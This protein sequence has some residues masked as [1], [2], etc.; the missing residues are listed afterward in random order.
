MSDLEIEDPHYFYAFSID[1]S[2]EYN[3]YINNETNTYPIEFLNSLN[4]P[5]MPT[6]MLTL[7]PGKTM[8]LTHTLSLYDGLAEGKHVVIKEIVGKVLV[9]T[10]VDDGKE[11][12]IPRMNLYSSDGLPFQLHRYQFPLCEVLINPRSREK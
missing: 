1:W 4:P 11:A 5:Q 9:V 12:Y 6:H 2:N 7:Y 8:M 10:K 3:S